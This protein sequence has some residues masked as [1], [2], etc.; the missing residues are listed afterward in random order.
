MAKDLLSVTKSTKY[1]LDAF[2][3]VQRGLDFTVRRI[4]GELRQGAEPTTSRHV[5]GQE[6]CLGLR[7][8]A[9]DQYGLL[10]RTVLRRWHITTSEDFGHIVFTMVDAGLMQKTADDTIR[11]F[12]GVFDFAEAF[13]GDVQLSGNG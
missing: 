2:L 12:S 3:F 1:P 10:A 6:L 11:D 4:H 7:D 13:A 9:L 5:S 8:F